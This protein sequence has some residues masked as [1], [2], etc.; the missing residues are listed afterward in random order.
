MFL[1]LQLAAAKALQLPA[2]FHE[3]VNAIYSARRK[4]VVELL[5]LLNCTFD[6]RQAGL[7]MWAAIPQEFE[8]GYALSDKVLY[9]SNVFITPGGIFGSAGNGYVRI[10][11]CSSEQKITEAIDR[12][13]K[14]V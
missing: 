3:E 14:I 10:S 2:S 4:K 9:Q 6:E 11:L 12:I 7:F 8:D 1:P 13:K 5:N